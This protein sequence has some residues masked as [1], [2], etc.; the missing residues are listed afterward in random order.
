MQSL[1][2]PVIEGT[3]RP[4]RNSIQAARYVVRVGQELEGVETELVDPKDYDM[5]YDGNNE[6]VKDPKYTELTEKADGFFVIV[7]EYNHSFPGTLKRLMDSE[8]E[9]YRR[10]PVAF[11][12]V[13][14]GPWGGIRGIES[15]VPVVREM[16]LIASSVDMMFPF[17]QKAFDE[18]G[19]PT[20]DQTR[21]RVFSA[22]DELLWLARTLKAGREN[23]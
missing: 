9:N 17:I 6:E 13:S 11:A 18:D 23:S 14:A 4:N 16:G 19:N 3:T 10:K 22:Y 20:D 12:G 7:P 1:Y 8:L 15:L 21:E 2:I 5:P